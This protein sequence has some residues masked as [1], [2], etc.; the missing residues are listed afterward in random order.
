MKRRLT[1]Y[2]VALSFTFLL[3]LITAAAT[4]STPQTL[5]PLVS[6]S[7]AEFLKLP[8]DMQGI[9]VAGV[10]DGMTFTSYGYSLPEHD[11]FVR[12]VRTLTV[13]ETS[14]A[15]V[16]WLQSHPTSD[17]PATAV[18]QALGAHCKAKGLR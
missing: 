4:A 1:R 3:V 8:R 15:T 10:I 12:C 18:A 6:I 5:G 13:G 17:G 9:Y 14:D 7:P 11:R 2:R 16:K